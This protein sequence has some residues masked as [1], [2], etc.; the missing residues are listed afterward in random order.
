MLHVAP[1]E[2]MNTCVRMNGVDTLLQGGPEQGC[3][4]T[5]L[6]V[7]PMFWQHPRGKFVF[8]PLHFSSRLPLLAKSSLPLKPSSTISPWGIHLEQPKDFANLTC[9]VLRGA[10]K[11]SE[12]LHLQQQAQCRACKD[13][14][15]TQGCVQLSMLAWHSNLLASCLVALPMTQS[16]HGPCS[17]PRLSS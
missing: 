7:S 10:L 9:L 17:R 8:A 11:N 6:F 13:P 2:E 16:M 15:T 3:L 1:A 12:P 4:Q 5:T 14:P